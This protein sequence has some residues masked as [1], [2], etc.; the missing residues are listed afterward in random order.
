MIK[1]GNLEKIID[2]ATGEEM[3]RVT[4]KGRTFADRN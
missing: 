3:I 2:P 4:E 1:R